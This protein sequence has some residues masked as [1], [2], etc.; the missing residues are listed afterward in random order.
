[1][2]APL[3]HTRP[4]SIGLIGA[5]WRA[6]YFLRIAR[7][8]P[9][10][11]EISGV[12]VRSEASAAAAR[13]RW[14]VHATT[15]LAVFLRGRYDYVI[16]STPVEAAADLVSALVA[17]GIPALTETPPAG[18]V[19]ALVAMYARVG[20]APVQVA[21]QYHLQPHHAAR[22]AVAASGVIGEVTGTRVSAAHGYHGLSLARR[23]LGS[24]VESVRIT[25]AT[26]A[27][28][29]VSA[30]GREGWKDELVE[31]GNPRTVALLRFESDT[32]AV[33]DFAEEQYFSPVRSRS[34]SVRGTRGEIDG[35]LVD[36]MLAPGRAVHARLERD[37]T[38]IDGDL[39]GSH[40]RGIA[41]NE[42]TVYANRFAPARLGDD[43]LAVAEL[44]HRMAGFVESGVEVYS[45]AE[46]SQDQYL[47]LLVERAAQT[48]TEVV[49]EP[50]PWTARSAPLSSPPSASAAG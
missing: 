39:D 4:A 13:E 38:G 24:G 12:L 25:A 6:E 2:T 27:D 28:R 17:A 46:A 7:E 41:L 19:D 21:E 36:Y 31:T 11:F 18:D 37:S 8:L 20:G 30:R 42:T 45:L 15:A 10:R 49:S 44:M 9:D 14:G 1:M 50:M 40:L 35:D 32:T 29:V 23:A 47:A 34:F 5:G 33:F 26:V 16:V 22:L 3:E 48:G 43:E